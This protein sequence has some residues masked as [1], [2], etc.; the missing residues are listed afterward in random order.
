MNIDCKLL[1]EKYLDTNLSPEFLY[2]H[3]YFKSDLCKAFVSYYLAFSELTDYSIIF[4]INAFIA[5]T[6]Y[7]CSEQRLRFLLKRLQFIID[8]LREAEANFDLVIVEKI[9][10]G[11]YKLARNICEAHSGVKKL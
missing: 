3:K 8:K 11:K 2:L 10:S 7:K 1:G 9:K 5:H 4:F 6:G